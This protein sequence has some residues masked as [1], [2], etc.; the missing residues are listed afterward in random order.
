MPETQ[1]HRI[2]WAIA[3]LL[4]TAGTAP[5][6]VPLGT[7]VTFQGQLKNGGVAVTDT[8]DMD[9]DL[10]DAETNGTM[11]GSISIGLVDVSDGLFDVTLDFGA[12]VYVGD[13]RWLEIAVQC[14]GDAG[15][16]TLLPRSPLTAVPFAVYASNTAVGHSLDADDGSPVDALYVNQ[17]GQVGIGWT[18]PQFP[19]HVH[20]G[21][22]T[23][24]VPANSTAV[25]GSSPSGY[26]VVGFSTGAARAGVW[27]SNSATSGD[28]RAISSLDS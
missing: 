5:A 22:G 15:A 21:A 12:G 24:T 7:S 2:A 11:I 25:F 13:A 17:F 6:A 10:W 19:L 20:H 28:A 3:V 8:C 27:G 4:L 16:T 18:T 1:T 23:P 14:T 9:F 26:G